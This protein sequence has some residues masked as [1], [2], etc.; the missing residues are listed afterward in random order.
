MKAFA[1]KY[2]EINDGRF[3]EIRITVALDSLEIKGSGLDWSF[4]GNGNVN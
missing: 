2:L 4:T 1:G 3:T